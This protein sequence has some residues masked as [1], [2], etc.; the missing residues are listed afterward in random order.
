MQVRVRLPKTLATLLLIIA[1]MCGTATCQSAAFSSYHGGNRYY[2]D[3][4]H[5]QL[6][7]TP[8]W[9]DDDPNPPLSV[10]QARLVGTEYLKQLFADAEKWTIDEITLH[11]IGDRWVYL[12]SFAEPPPPDCRDCMTFPFRVVVTMEGV[13]VPASVSPWTPNVPAQVSSDLPKARAQGS[14][15]L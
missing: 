12:I 8:A 13:A 3:L 7:K 1:G 10:R 15:A 11:P 6:E 2:F 4:T 9:H 5:D 14:G